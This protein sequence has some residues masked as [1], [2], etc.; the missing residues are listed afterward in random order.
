M[1]AGLHARLYPWAPT[2][3]LWQRDVV[4]YRGPL[5]KTAPY[6]HRLMRQLDYVDGAARLPTVSSIGVAALY[7]PPRTPNLNWFVNRP[8]K[9]RTKDKIR[10]ILRL[11]GPKRSHYSCPWCA[12]VW[13]F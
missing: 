4:I 10:L 9:D 11:G 7:K 6:G 2:E 12:R 13:R 5:S 1:A 8:D 3:G